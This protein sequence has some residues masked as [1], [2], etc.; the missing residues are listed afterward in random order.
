[1]DRKPSGFCA[2]AI[3][4]VT[5]SLGVA[6]SSITD[7]C[8]KAVRLVRCSDKHRQSTTPPG[9][10][11]TEYHGKAVASIRHVFRD[12]ASAAGLKKVTSHTLRQ[13]CAT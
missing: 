1:M 10:S 3:R 6:A 4:M 11:V 12:R 5:R 9:S 8:A 13:T 2:S 7:H